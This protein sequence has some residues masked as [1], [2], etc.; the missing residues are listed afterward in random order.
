[1]GVA[2]RS[3]ARAPSA[4]PKSRPPACLTA[5]DCYDR[6]LPRMLALPRLT[7][8]A[9]IA[10]A[11][12]LSL[13]AA[14]RLPSVLGEHMVVQRGLPVHIWGFADPGETVSATFRGATGSATADDLGR[15]S[16]YLPPGDAG[17]PFELVIRGTNQIALRDVLAGDVWVASGQSNMEWVVKNA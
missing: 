1:M 8:I 11:A 15:W 6:H 5:A 17:G 16:I 3:S 7:R 10:L 12:G 14:V 9:A 13:H 4:G 2:G